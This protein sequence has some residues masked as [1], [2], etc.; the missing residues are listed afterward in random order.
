MLASTSF[1]VKQISQ[2]HCQLF[3]RAKVVDVDGRIARWQ[4]VGDVGRAK[5]NCANNRTRSNARRRAQQQ[6]RSTWNRANNK[7]VKQLRARKR[8]M[9]GARRSRIASSPFPSHSRAQSSSPSL[10]QTGIYARRELKQNQKRKRK[11]KRL[12]S[13]RCSTWPTTTIRCAIRSA[14][15]ERESLGA[16]SHFSNPKKRNA[17]IGYL[18][19]KALSVRIDLN[20]THQLGDKLTATC[21]DLRRAKARNT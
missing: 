14:F 15:P 6:H 11:K 3:G 21:F 9:N 13:K 12:T 1:V 4:K 20:E 19:V 7:G 10:A 18:V 5:I 17:L 2:I 16:F 8:T